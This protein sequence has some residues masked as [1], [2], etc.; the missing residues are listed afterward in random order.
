MLFG[1]LKIK[2]E[3]IG[4]ILFS[5]FGK[6]IKSKSSTSLYLII[7]E[8]FIFCNNPLASQIQQNIIKKTGSANNLL[9][10]IDSIRFDISETQME[11]VL[12]NGSLESH[13]IADIK[14]AGFNDMIGF[15]SCGAL[16]IH[17]PNMIYGALTDQEG[18]VYKTIIIGNQEWMAENLNTGKYRNGDTISFIDNKTSWRNNGPVGAWCY[19]E[20]DNLYNCP[21]GKIY[22]WYAVADNRNICP[23]GW[24]VPTD[25]EWTALTLYLG[26]PNSAGAAMKSTDFNYWKYPN[27]GNNISGFSAL[28]GGRR[29]PPSYNFPLGF[30]ASIN[31]NGYWWSSTS[32]PSSAMDAWY[33]DISS[34]NGAILRSHSNKYQGLNV[35]CIRDK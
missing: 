16:T 5:V 15:H 20:D 12:Q 34:H 23:A 8:V 3:K 18:N 35:R 2:M 27:P 1:A 28:P 4:A 13:A 33:R 30:C 19:Y 9:S 25:I 11:V 14:M 26:G 22:N 29:A 31:E 10:A 32:Y 24:H 6:L 17:N 21:Y 7:A